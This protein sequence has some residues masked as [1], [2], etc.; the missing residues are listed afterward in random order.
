MIRDE[1]IQHYTVA[2]TGKNVCQ[3]FENLTD[4]CSM[5]V[6]NTVSTQTK[7]MQCF[8]PTVRKISSTCST[9]FFQL[10]YAEKSN[11]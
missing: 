10:S 9:R 5:R 7:L 3:V 2:L 6:N 1:S 11:H 8:V 4:V